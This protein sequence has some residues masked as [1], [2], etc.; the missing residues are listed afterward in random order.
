MRAPLVGLSLAVAPGRAAYVPLRHEGL[1]EQ[2]PLA[3][4]IAALGP[5]LTDRNTLKIY[6]NAKFDM[7]VMER[8][9]FPPSAPFDD[10]MLISYAQ[11]AGMHGHGL[12]EL[13]RC[14][15]AIRRSATTRSPAPGATAFR[16][17]RCRSSAPPPMRRRTPM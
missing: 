7:L 3:A 5:V 9:G 1:A 4:A 13:S 15:S 14:I 16:S 8:A 17:R 6:Q 10:A 2:V 11:E 12:D